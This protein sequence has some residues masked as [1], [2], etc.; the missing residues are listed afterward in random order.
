[1][2]SCRDLQT[3]PAEAAA[4]EP[5]DSHLAGADCARDVGLIMSLY[6]QAPSRAP[7]RPQRLGGRGTP[8]L[9]SA[10][11]TVAR[12]WWRLATTVNPAFKHLVRRCLRR[13]LICSTV[14]A[15]VTVS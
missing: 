6:M 10:S 14:L 13:H 2:P 5:A 1:V 12:Y 3:Q 9:V 11:S 15:A 8:S 4:D 7:G